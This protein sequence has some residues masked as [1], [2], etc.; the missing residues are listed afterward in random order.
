MKIIGEY[1]KLDLSKSNH[2][3]IWISIKILLVLFTCVA[4][5]VI[6]RLEDLLSLSGSFAAASISLVLPSFFH[7]F[8]FKSV[9]QFSRVL[10]VLDIII[11]IVGIAGSVLGTYA[12]TVELLS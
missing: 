7:F 9:E 1:L 3:I 8:C 5:V 12:A 11:V 2:T 10:L 6:P 4:A